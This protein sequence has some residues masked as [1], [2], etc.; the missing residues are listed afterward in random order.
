MGG[1]TVHM[2]GMWRVWQYTWRI[3]GGC[4]GT[5]GG[6]VGCVTVHMV[7]MCGCGSTHSGHVVGVAA[8]MVDMWWVW[9]YTWWACGGC[10][11]TPG[12]YVGV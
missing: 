5:P 7:G 10:D 11:S 3:C 4:D 12:G 6:H 9:Q 2:V 1:V 8:H